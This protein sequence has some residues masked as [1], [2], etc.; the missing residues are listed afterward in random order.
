MGDFPPEAGPKLRKKR[1]CFRAGD[2]LMLLETLLNDRDVF[3]LV[4]SRRV[5][6]WEVITDTL[7]RQ[8][9]S[10]TAHSLRCRLKRLVETFQDGVAEGKQTAEFT[11]LEKLLA[12]YTQTE[13]Q[14]QQRK[15]MT[16]PQNV[17]REQAAGDRTSRLSVDSQH[18]SL[19]SVSENESARYITTVQPVTTAAAPVGV[20]VAADP[21]APS[22]ESG[23]KS[24]KK[25]FF[26]ED[27]HDVVLLK[28]MLADRGMVMSSGTK[29]P[30]WKN[31]EASVNSQGLQV[32]I[33][34]IRTHLRLLLN[35]HRREEHPPN[36]DQCELSEK[37]QL[38]RAY[39]KKMD[40]EGQQNRG[41]ND[42]QS[43]EPAP[44]R[45]SAQ[46]YERRSETNRSQTVASS[47][48]PSESILAN[49]SAV[50]A[51]NRPTFTRNAVATTTR[52]AESSPTSP[53]TQSSSAIQ[54]HG[55]IASSA[56]IQSAPRAP[57]VVQSL[58]VTEEREA[59]EPASKRQK[60]ELETILQ[61]FIAEQNECQREQREHER[62]RLSEQRDLQRQ[63]ID[64]QKRSL[65]I[66]EKA[67]NM[68]ER[69][70][71][72]M[73]KVMDKLN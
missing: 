4:Q 38:L 72:V 60:M 10:A 63:T 26:F 56:S 65:D 5:R 59:A 11:A 9:I 73:E 22:P 44:D 27:W 46:S 2:D 52:T 41:S 3:S 69:L 8:G 36:T 21:S 54:Y 15:S 47:A 13:A 62:T 33:H 49:P 18:S 20:R 61:R 12:Q 43:F 64:L 7:N 30:A 58:P 57:R 45:H 37:Q 1:Y 68:Q 51:G 6:A 40:E 67:M 29:K 19:D 35:A 71:A 31:I 55:V 34:T 42:D 14:Y 28:A 23:K 50:S 17:L 70:M 66:Q 48:G 32:N 39:I 24:R 16:R 25:R 53:A